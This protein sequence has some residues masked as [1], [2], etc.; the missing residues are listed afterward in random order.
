MAET[1]QYPCA[2]RRAAAL[3]LLVDLP[4]APPRPSAQV[5]SRGGI[6]CGVT[7]QPHVWVLQ[8]RAHSF[9]RPLAD[10]RVGGSS[11]SRQNPTRACSSATVGRGYP[12]P[13]W[14]GGTGAGRIGDAHSLRPGVVGRAH[15]GWGRQATSFRSA[16]TRTGFA[17]VRRRRTSLSRQDP[18]FLLGQKLHPWGRTP[19]GV[20]RIATTVY[21]PPH[22]TTK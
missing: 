22:G 16:S 19:L 21:R 7:V 9:G 6:S 17:R 14:K 3:L 11:G 18:S 1:V 8:S 10:T 4:S 15:Q 20:R 5:P 13:R 2:R 12:P